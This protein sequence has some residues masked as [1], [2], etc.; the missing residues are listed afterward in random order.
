MD[1]LEQLKTKMKILKFGGPKI[2]PILAFQGRKFSF[3]TTIN[4]RN[5]KVK[6]ITINKLLLRG[7]PIFFP[8]IYYVF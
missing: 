6:L 3:Q 7:N 5:N 8:I 2:N 1:W 4:S